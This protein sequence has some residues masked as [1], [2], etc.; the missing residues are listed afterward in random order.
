MIRGV[1]LSVN[2]IFFSICKLHLRVVARVDARVNVVGVVE[3]QT[4]LTKCDRQMD[5]QIRTQ[6]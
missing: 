6:T 3:I 4:V 2:V 1:K 5:T